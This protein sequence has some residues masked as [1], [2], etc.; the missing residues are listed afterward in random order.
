MAAGLLVYFASI[1]GWYPIAI[2]N[3]R[4]ITART[5]VRQTSAANQYYTTV[6]KIQ[7][8]PAE[9]LDEIKRAALDKLIE[10]A[11]IYSE[12]LEK[13][14]RANQ[15][16]S[17]RLDQLNLDKQKIGEVSVALYGLSFSEFR[18]MVLLPEARKEILVDRLIAGGQQ[19]FAQ[20]LADAKTKASVFILNNQFEWD[21][22]K[23]ELRD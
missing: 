17:A 1:Q 16:V 15:L 22:A 7:N 11:L 18:D 12:L 4:I 13:E 8:L 10:N 14:S 23:I 9:S 3:S 5:L 21:G 20:W 2:A 19:D 6:L